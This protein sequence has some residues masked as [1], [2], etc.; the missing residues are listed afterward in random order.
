[1][2]DY[3]RIAAE[4]ARHR[5]V[6]TEVL[7][8]LTTGLQPTATVLEVGCGTGNYLIAIREVVGCSCWGIDPSAEM[9][10]QARARSKQVQVLQGTAERLQFPDGQ[11]DFVFSVDV[12]HHVGDRGRS[13]REG[14]DWAMADVG[15]GVGREFLE[16]ITREM[17]KLKAQGEKAIAQVTDDRKLHLKLDEQSNSIDIIVRHLAGNMVSRWTD[18]LTT[19]GE[20]PTRKRDAEF[21][22]APNL[23]RA[24]IIA[25]WEKGWTC[26]FNTLGALTPADLQ[27]RV[28]VAGQEFSALDAILRQSLHYAAHVGQIMSLAKH[29]EWQHWQSLSVPLKKAGKSQPGLFT[30]FS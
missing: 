16:I 30:D 8:R 9:L 7:R 15:Q 5:R 26:L 23:T 21:E 25:S 29:L 27:Q 3:D 11:F 19:D 10:A 17:R 12:I 28:R 24:E 13:F 20:K 6:H 4:Y 2:I 22:P 1:M 18:F 14:E